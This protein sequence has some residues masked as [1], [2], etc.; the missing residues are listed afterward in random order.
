[1]IEMLFTYDRL[2]GYTD[3]FESIEEVAEFWGVRPEI[4]QYVLDKGLSFMDYFLD[5]VQ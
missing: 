2:S 1:M 3:Y 4:A 5:E